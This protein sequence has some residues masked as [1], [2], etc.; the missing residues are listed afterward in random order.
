[1][2]LRIKEREEAIQ[3]LA[4]DPQVCGKVLTLHQQGNRVDVDALRDRIPLRQGAEK[5][6]QMGSHGNKRLRQWK[7]VSLDASGGLGIFSNIQEEDLGQGVYEGPTR[8]GGGALP[9]WARPPPLWPPRGSSDLHSKSSGC[10]LV[11]NKSS[12]CLIFLF[13]KTQKQGKTETDTGLQ[14]NRL[15]PKII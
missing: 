2:V 4:M 12:R 9:P 13:C 3:L 14:V 15:V 1:M 6:P 5:G 8:S 7:S 11:Q 10:L